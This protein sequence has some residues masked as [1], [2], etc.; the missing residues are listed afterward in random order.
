MDW[1]TDSA[2]RFG[3]V[4]RLPVI[5]SQHGPES[6][7]GH[8]RHTY[9][10]L[11]QVALQQGLDEIIAPGAA[12][13]I[14]AREIRQGKSTAQPQA[15]L[16]IAVELPNV[17]TAQRQLLDPAGQALRRLPLQVSRRTPQDQESC[18]RVAPV[19]Q[20]AQHGE[21][22]GAPLDLVDHHQ[23][24]QWLQGRH[25]LL[26]PGEID[27]ILQIEIL[28]RILRHD[29]PRQCRLAALARSHKEHDP[30]AL[31]RGSQSLN[32]LPARNHGRII[33]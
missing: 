25:R 27:R 22:I 30:A 17:E 2:R 19:H 31:E 13:G 18:R 7:Q 5:V 28:D 9:A 4:P 12:I 1:L 21:Q 8:G 33:P 23:P 11:R 15:G 32:M 24:A 6:P 10:P 29:L 26:Q 20:H 14:V 16:G 3:S